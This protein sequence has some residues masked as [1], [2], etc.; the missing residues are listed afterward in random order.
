MTLQRPSVSRGVVAR[1]TETHAE[2]IR[3]RLSVWAIK[4]QTRRAYGA[5][6]FE[7]PVDTVVVARR[8]RSGTICLKAENYR[9]VR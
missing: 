1:L 8:F 2:I 5:V 4:H 9:Q 7:T 6:L 3:V